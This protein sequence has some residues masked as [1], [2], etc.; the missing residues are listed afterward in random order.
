[1][2]HPLNNVT[3]TAVMMIL[4][5]K[6]RELRKAARQVV[7]ECGANA[8]PSRGSVEK[9]RKLLSDHA[10]GPAGDRGQVGWMGGEGP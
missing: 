3:A 10:E 2:K 8:S 5:G 9:L 7:D 1:M 4:E 6:L